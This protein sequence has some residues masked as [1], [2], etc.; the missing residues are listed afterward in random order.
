MLAD[1]V[2]E[3]NKLANTPLLLL[4]LAPLLTRLTLPLQLPFKPTSGGAGARG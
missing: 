2:E 1:T 4:L 3:A